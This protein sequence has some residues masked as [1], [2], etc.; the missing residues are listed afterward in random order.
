MLKNIPFLVQRATR[1]HLSFNMTNRDTCFL[2]E[3]ATMSLLLDLLKLAYTVYKNMENTRELPYFDSLVPSFVPRGRSSKAHIL[4]DPFNFF[5]NRLLA[6]PAIS[7][8]Q[9]LAT[10]ILKLEYPDSEKNAQAASSG[11]NEA[12]DDSNDKKKLNIILNLLKACAHLETGNTDADVAKKNL[13]ELTPHFEAAF[14]NETLRSKHPD[15]A[16]EANYFLYKA[17]EFVRLTPDLKKIA[18]LR[19]RFL[20]TEIEAGQKTQKIA[21][22]EANVPAL[23]TTLSELETKHKKLEELLAQTTVQNL[24]LVADNRK[25]IEAQKQYDVEII[26]LKKVLYGSEKHL[27]ALEQ[28]T[29]LDKLKKNYDEL[30]LAHSQDRA[31]A[32]KAQAKILELKAEIAELQKLNTILETQQA[33]QSPTQS[34]AA[35]ISAT[36]SISSSVF[37][38]FRTG[39][40]FGSS[41]RSPISA[42]NNNISTNPP[43]HQQ[44][45]LGIAIP[46]QT[47]PSGLTGRK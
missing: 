46:T 7:H 28:Q 14:A 34:K 45:I 30:K 13:D 35:T 42:M 8:D 16:R 5:L 18:H 39:S 6:E 32:K 38:S 47:K 11:G 31:Y 41:N 25:L 9:A 40:L 1:T 2:R 21:E 15:V 26:N 17:Y 29:T 10:E 23:E 19:Q 36:G 24:S 22:L 12:K 43:G 20:D 33:S 27:M 37:S 3:D 4:E 44:I